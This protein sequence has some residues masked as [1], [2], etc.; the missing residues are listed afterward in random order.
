MDKNN[1]GYFGEERAVRYLRLHGYSILARNYAFRGGEIDIIAR[2]RG[3]VAF[4]EVKLRKNDAFGS[5]R[6]FVTPLKQEKILM[7]AE[8]WLSQN[9]CELQPRF[10]VI[11]IYAPEGERGRLTLN[12]IENAF[13]M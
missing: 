10:D 6:E 7:T 5:A 3:I 8:L 1:I 2:K 13:G 4:V 9:E 12:H 11:E